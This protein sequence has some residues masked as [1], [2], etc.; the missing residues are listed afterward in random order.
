MD[1]HAEGNWPCSGIKLH[2]E[3]QCRS[4]K[5]AW[6]NPYFKMYEWEPIWHICYWCP[7]RFP[8]YNFQFVEAV[9]SDDWYRQLYVHTNSYK[10]MTFLRSTGSFYEKSHGHHYCGVVEGGVFVFFG[11]D[12]FFGK[13]VANFAGKCICRWNC[14]YLIIVSVSSN[15]LQII[16]MICDLNNQSLKLSAVHFWFVLSSGIELTVLY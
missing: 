6:K 8:P 12:K 1:Q 10:M 3:N 15:K 4:L 5:Q 14:C 13:T 7:I 2:K 9:C 11:L 16:G